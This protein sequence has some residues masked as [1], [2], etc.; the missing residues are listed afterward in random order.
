MER[1]VGID[2]SQKSL[3]V[4]VLPE[5]RCRKYSYDDKGIQ[6]IIRKL[7]KVRPTLVVMEAT[8]GLETNLAIQLCNAGFEHVLGVVNPRQ[9]RDY[10]RAT[11]RLAKTDKIDALVLAGFARDLRPKVRRHLNLVELAGKELI[12]RRHQLIEMRSGEKSR[13]S[14]VGSERIRASIDVVIRTLDN[15]IDKIDKEIDEIIQGNTIYQEKIKLMISVPGIAEK[16]AR[17]LLFLLPELGL[18]NRQEIASLVGVAPMNQDSGVYRGRRRITGGRSLVREVLH[19]PTLAASTRWNKQLMGFYQQLV[20][21]GK[22]HKTALTA[23]M[24]KLV[25]ILNSMMKNGE[26]YR[27]SATA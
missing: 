11:G 5:G 17:A 27:Y 1:F 20:G 7:K 13:R 8:G 14:R 22:K 3:D 18:V 9:V 6:A 12:S 19:M 15:Q 10:G 25:T 16:T 4:A 2:I 24:R 23:C 26:Y 21:A